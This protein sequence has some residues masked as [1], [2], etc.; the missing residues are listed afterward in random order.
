MEVRLGLGTQRSKGPTV[1]RG[2]RKALDPTRRLRLCRR[3]YKKIEVDDKRV[4]QLN[5]NAGNRS[6]ESSARRTSPVAADPPPPVTELIVYH[7]LVAGSSRLAQYYFILP[8]TPIHPSR[9]PRNIIFKQALRD[10]EKIPKNKNMLRLRTISATFH[11][12]DI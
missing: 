10:E 3:L 8:V 1:G 4:G 12:I 7:H 5:G 2:R 9:K 6:D 11:F